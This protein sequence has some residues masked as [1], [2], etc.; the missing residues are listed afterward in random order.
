MN[1][2]S[3]LIIA[4]S[5]A[6]LLLSSGNARA[7]KDTLKNKLSMGVNVL[8]H[9][10]ICA[11]GLPRTDGNPKEDNSAFLV[12]RIRLNADYERKNLQAHFVLQ[13]LWVWGMK[14]NQALNLY[15]GW[16]KMG[17]RVGLFAQLGR[18]A[19]A[20]DDERII[21][22]ND[23]AAAALS[24]D[25]LRLGYEGHGHQLHV[26]LAYNQNGDNVYSGNYYSGGAQYY[27]TMQTVWYHY[28]IPKF[29]L[30]ASLLFMNM[31]LQAGFTDSETNPAHYGNPAR[32][33]YQ[34]MY[35]AYLRYHPKRFSAEASYYRQSG[36][37]VDIGSM[38]PKPI[39]AW[40]A[41]VKLTYDPS[42]RYGFLL[43]Y[44]HLSGDD[45][46]PVTFGGIGLPYHAVYK[47]FTPLYGSRTKFYGIMDYF[48]ESAF[49]HGFTPGL[50]N[51][52]FGV[53]GKP[54]EAIS[55]NATYHYLAVATKIQDLGMTL[56]HSLEIKASYQ[57]T[58]DISLSAGYTL[59]AGT[60]TM[61]RLKQDGASPFAHWG[62]ISLVV[63][64]KLFST[65]F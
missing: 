19:L 24:H 60:E 53:T 42:D 50:Q 3:A 13:N 55:L 6:A 62:W 2:K 65:R 63:A 58:K 20:Y 23:F 61:A 1:G 5:A 31:G 37:F 38:S 16:V 41:S 7:Q 12:G 21:G 14:N 51:A 28:D 11:G 48:Y 49:I 33:E 25:V 8:G 36:K 27:K 39:D 35:G 30:G 45:F 46:V 59:M 9:G 15:E 10:E 17:T 26:I 40:M 18:V 32:M 34:Q 29:P 4:L 52:F 22:T 47:G 54:I 57:I 43:G 44:D 56:G 64:P